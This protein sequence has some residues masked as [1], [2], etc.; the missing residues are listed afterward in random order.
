MQVKQA[1]SGK[2]VVRP[3]TRKISSDHRCTT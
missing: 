2:V 1:V 3:R